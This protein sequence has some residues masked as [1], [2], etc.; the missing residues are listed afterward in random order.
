MLSSVLE[1]IKS[2][3]HLDLYVLK[4]FIKKNTARAARTL[5]CK[6][7]VT[8]E[9]YLLVFAENDVSNFYLENSLT[10]QIQFASYSTSFKLNRPVVIGKFKK[11]TFVLYQYFNKYKYTKNK[12]PIRV[13]KELYSEKAEECEINKETLQKIEENLLTAWHPKYHLSI[14]GLKRFREYFERLSQYR[15][16]RLFFEH[17]DFTSNNILSIDGELYLMDFEFGRSFQPIGFDIYDY[18]RCSKRMISK[19]VCCY[20]ELHQIKYHLI[21]E[22]NQIIDRSE[23]DIK[24]YDNFDDELKN[25]WETLYTQTG[26]PYNLTYDWCYKWFEHFG[27]GKK[28]FIITIWDKDKV[29]LIAPLYL[30]KNVVYLMG[31]NPDLFDEFNLI[32]YDRKDIKRF[33]EY[34]IHSKWDMDF[35]YLNTG[36]EVSK[37]ILRMLLQSEIRFSSE[38]VDTKPS[39]TFPYTFQKKQ[40]TDVK[41]NKSNI[42]VDCGETIKFEYETEKDKKYLNEFIIIHKKRWNGGPFQVL[43]GYEEFIYDLYLNTNLI[44]LSRLSLIESNT[45]IAYHL[46][47]RDSNNELTSSV[48]SYNKDYKKYS[49]GKIL[50][51]ELIIN[52]Q[53]RGLKSFDFGRGAEFYKYLFSNQDTVLIHVK[54]YSEKP[55]LFKLKSFVDKVLRRLYG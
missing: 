25:H 15:T 8:D 54:T 28:R 50:L 24:V 3:H 51:Y 22:I 13:L 29:K 12:L 16:I 11:L 38:V 26:G 44:V 30:V 55:R 35:R 39:L 43:K 52:L 34:L 47:Y 37:I 31:S 33:T 32:Y 4:E 14:R 19:E 48:P 2:E 1:L 41:R 36:S 5:L 40:T 21:T 18:L 9:N 17:G 10:K 20:K 23:A 53:Q 46:G 42:I 27:K 49:P 7:A 45:S 6:N